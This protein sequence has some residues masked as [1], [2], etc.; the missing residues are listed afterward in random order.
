MN[1]PTLIPG[2]VADVAI[3][4]GDLLQFTSEGRLGKANDV[5]IAFCYAIA[6]RLAD[7]PVDAYLLTP[8]VHRLK[9]SGTVAAGDLLKADSSN[10]GQLTPSAFDAGDQ[11]VGQAAAARTGAGFVDVIVGGISG[12]IAS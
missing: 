8:G 11:I 9:V 6:D 2:F 7:E 4:E 10:I 5:S 3:S 12:V 1:Y